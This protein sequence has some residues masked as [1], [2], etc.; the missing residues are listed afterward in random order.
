MAKLG[1]RELV[2]WCAMWCACACIAD[3]GTGALQPGI[4]Q[5]SGTSR[6]H[7]HCRVGHVSTGVAK[8][9]GSNGSPSMYLCPEKMYAVVRIWVFRLLSDHL[10][11]GA[12]PS[13]VTSLPHPAGKLTNTSVYR[14]LT[15]S[16]A[17]RK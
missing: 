10:S 3:R 17:L 11:L 9:Q 1:Q 7:M 5:V 2:L 15:P 13:R 16:C 6:A 4:R 14:A 12:M 8:A